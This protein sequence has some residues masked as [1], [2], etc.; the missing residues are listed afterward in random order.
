M[1]QCNNPSLETAQ[2]FQHVLS[3]YSIIIC[4]CDNR[5]LDLYL[6]DLWLLRAGHK[7][8]FG[9]EQATEKWDPQFLL[10]K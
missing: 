10:L 6:I 4:F 2:G 7:I 5:K 9:K 8:E 1:K 3:S